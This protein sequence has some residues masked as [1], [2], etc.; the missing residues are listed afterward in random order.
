M[1]IITLNEKIFKF[2][3]S[4]GCRYKK[5]T[6]FITNF[7]CYTFFV[8]Y[9]LGFIYILFYKQILLK[10]YIF[11]PFIT[12][13]IAKMLRKIIK[14][15]RPFEA[16]PIKSL[17]KHKGGNSMPSNHSASAM[18]LSFALS[19]VFPRFSFLFFLLAIITGIS[20]VMA[21]VHYPLDIIFGFFIGSIFGML[22][23]FSFF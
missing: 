7:S 20:R 15:K 23:F 19:A 11:Y 16:M 2:I 18:V 5:T 9:A 22:G 3:F 10:R 13:L 4:I 12:I 1:V 14:S 21:G 6:V 8:L 17:I